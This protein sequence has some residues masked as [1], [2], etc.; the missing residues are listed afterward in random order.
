MDQLNI[1]HRTINSLQDAQEN[2]EWLFNSTVLNNVK[3]NGSDDDYAAIQK[4]L[5]DG[6]PTYLSGHYKISQLLTVPDGSTLLGSGSQNTDITCIAPGAGI[7]FGGGGGGTAT[8]HGIVAGFFLKG[9]KLTG[10]GLETNT[11]ETQY[12]DVKV[13]QVDGDCFKIYGQ[14]NYYETCLAGDTSGSGYLLD[15]GCGAN[16]FDRCGTAFCDGNAVRVKFTGV[17]G[18]TI[19]TWNVFYQCLFEKNGSPNF[20]N[21]GGPILYHTAG[22]DNKFLETAFYCNKANIDGILIEKDGSSSNN[23]RITLRDCEVIG[24][25]PGTTTAAGLHANAVSGGVAGSI[26]GGVTV[27][28]EGKNIFSAWQDGIK[29]GSS[30]PIFNDGS[31]PYFF[32]CANAYTLDGTGA[33]PVLGPELDKKLRLGN[34]LIDKLEFYDGAGTLSNRYGFG[35]KSGAVTHYHPAGSRLA[36]IKSAASGEAGS[37]TEMMAFYSN[38]HID[39]TEMATPPPAPGANIGRLFTQDNG[40]GKTQ[41]CVRFPTGAVQVIA[42][43]P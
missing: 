1:P 38:G 18:Y 31:K 14:N 35:L 36:I 41:I 34:E 25:A 4:S 6:G 30:T 42:T 40:A 19:P 20:S 21:T 39:F 10:P 12:S 3:A 8:R 5:N 33:S 13:N 28:L 17:G 43:E 27:V 29:W 9:G 24:T 2:W 26:P 32:S 37:G 11:V 16:T 22:F 15:Y 23:G 7:K